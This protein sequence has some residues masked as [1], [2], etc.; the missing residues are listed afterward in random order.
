MQV[1]SPPR[2]SRV[3]PIDARRLLCHSSSSS[4]SCGL[5]DIGEALTGGPVCAKVQPGASGTLPRGEGCPWNL[6]TC[7][8]AV[9]KGHVEVLRWA[10]QNGCPWTASTRDRAAAE[11]GYT[12]DFGNIE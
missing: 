6:W 12:D 10:R 4:S 9:N 7:D 8:S 3:K 1:E 11:L 5:S 2:L